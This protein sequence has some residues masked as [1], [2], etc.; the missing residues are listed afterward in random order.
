PALVAATGNRA[1]TGFTAPKL[2]WLRE[3]EP[4]VYGRIAHIL[5][6]KDYSACG[7]AGSGR[8]TSPTRPARCCST[9]RSGWS[10]EV[11]SALEIDMGWLPRAL[12]SP[13][14]SGETSDG[15]PVAAGAGDQVAGALGVGVVEAG[16][17]LS[18]VL[19]TS[20]VVFSALPEFAADERRAS[21]RSATRCRR[22]GTRWA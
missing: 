2:L 15:I 14:V 9:L 1:L 8:S 20:G 12:E 22:P 7:C 3:H 11:C 4:D 10:E 5:L 16:A 6:P 17:S 19:G 18:V 21:T 13:E